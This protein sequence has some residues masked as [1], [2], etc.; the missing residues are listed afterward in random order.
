MLYLLRHPRLLPVHGRQPLDLL[1]PRP[2]PHRRV[3]H[4]QAGQLP[5]SI[6]DLSH[7]PREEDSNL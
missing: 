2:L 3:A 6:V 5:V 7:N 4:A 1:K